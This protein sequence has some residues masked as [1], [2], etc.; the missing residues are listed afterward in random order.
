MEDVAVTLTDYALTVE[1]GVLAALI[2][3]WR[4]R[5]PLWTWFILLFV[6]LSVAT[7]VGGTAHGFASRLGDG[8]QANLLA[9]TRFC[10]GATSLATWSIGAHVLFRAPVA[11]WVVRGAVAQFV[12]YSFVTL[13]VTPAF[14]VSLVE[15]LPATVFLLVACARACWR[16][17]EPRIYPIL[18]GL[19]LTFAAAYVEVRKIGLHPTYFNSSA[20]YHLIQAVAL[21]LIFL[22][23]RHLPAV[24]RST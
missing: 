15:Y 24:S 1:C 5:Q 20:L 9:V 7:L 6:S 14:W 19:L 18:A 22:A 8:G 17:R 16:S 4:P 2:A 11:R 23:V 13:V 12:A 10:I 21:V 3:L